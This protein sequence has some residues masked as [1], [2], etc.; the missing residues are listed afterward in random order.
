MLLA[1]DT[2]QARP[3]AAIGAGGRL[4]ACAEAPAWSV[5]VVGLVRTALRRAGVDSGAL[6]ASLA[7]V[8]V[9]TGPGRFASLRSGIAVAKALALARGWPLVGVP[10]VPLLRHAACVPGAAVAIPAGR[11][12]YYVAMSPDADPAAGSVDLAEL[13]GR[14]RPG[15]A[16]V[17]Q[18]DVATE[19]AL[20]EAGLLPVTVT[21]TGALAAVAWAAWQRLAG[22]PSF[23]TPGAS[24]RYATPAVTPSTPRSAPESPGHA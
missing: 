2:S 7:A 8:A 14:C 24:P 21:S 6:P 20:F 1:I 16:V 11:G 22:A 19:R 3:C 17:G 4:V 15:E 9:A 18:F 23:A 13:A 10:T 12:R 5:D